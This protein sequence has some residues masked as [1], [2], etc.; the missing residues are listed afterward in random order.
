MKPPC[1]KAG[2]AL[3]LIIHAGFTTPSNRTSVGY[4]C[5]AKRSTIQAFSPGKSTGTRRATLRIRRPAP[6]SNPVPQSRDDAIPESIEIQDGLSAG[7]VL[8]GRYE[9]LKPIGQGGMSTVYLARDLR[10]SHVERLCAIK[11]MVN[12]ARDQRT[13]LLQLAN[14]EREASLLATMSHPAIPKI[15]D[16]FS[17][18][19]LIY[20]VLEFI[21]GQDLER[22]LA[23]IPEPFTE[24]QL[25][26]WAIQILDV[27]SYLHEHQPEPIVFRDLKPSN[28][29]LRSDQSIS[30]IDFGIARTFQ[31]FIKGTMIGTEGY[32]PPEQYRGIAE[33]RGDIYAM[34]ATLHHLATLSDPRL[35]PPFSFAQRMPRELNPELSPDFEAIILKAVSYNPGDR[36]PSAAAMAQSISVVGSGPK[37]GLSSSPLSPILDEGFAPAAQLQPPDKPDASLTPVVFGDEEFERVLWSIQTADEVRGTATIVN[38]KTFIGSYDQH[39]YV[40]RTEDGGILWRF[41][42]NRGIVSR[43]LLTRDLVV[44]GSEDYSIYGLSANTGRL[45]WS[46]RTAMP[47]RSSGAQYEEAV[48]IGA[49]DGFCYCLDAQQGNLLWRQ[50]TWGPIRSTPFIVRDQILVGSDDGSLYSL[51]AIDGRQRWRAPLGR[52]IHSSPTVDSGIAVVGCTDGSLYALDVLTGAARWRVRTNGM[53]IATPRIHMGMVIVG[54][55]DGMLHAVSLQTG[56]VIWAEQ[57][58]TQITSSVTVHHGAGYVGTIDGNL[59]CVDLDNGAVVWSHRVGSPIVSTPAIRD[60]VIVVG[61]LNGKIY[62]LRV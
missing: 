26:D 49:D 42:T 24:S 29:M 18:G 40:L 48:I 41:R 6:H 60:D 19:G 38:G 45:T 32:A 57:L 4:R 47:V 50:R 27:L 37:V 8:E 23:R 36:Y 7:T 43:P 62:G 46:F 55:A 13:Q 11:E 10:F 58:A 1:W 22:L 12:R 34:G 54:S 53:I 59:L 20:V 33:P 16:F 25:R 52:P 9:I 5:C 51:S 61:S 15:Y 56:E 28:I 2:V 39:L 35:E 30:L 17:N 31:P 21:E 14:F 44:F 3:A